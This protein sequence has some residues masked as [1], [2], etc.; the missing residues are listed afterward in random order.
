MFYE[1]IISSGI[2]SFFL[3]RQKFARIKV[4]VW[5]V[6]ESSSGFWIAS[7][8]FWTP[9]GENLETTQRFQLRSKLFSRLESAYEIQ[10]EADCSMT[11]VSHTLKIKM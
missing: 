7:H 2:S 9:T 10:Y 4:P 6:S 3:P 8:K 5:Y 1:N 11:R